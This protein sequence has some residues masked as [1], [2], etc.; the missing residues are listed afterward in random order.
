M[1]DHATTSGN[2][3]KPAHFFSFAN[4]GSTIAYYII[5]VVYILL[6][7]CVFNADNIVVSFYHFIGWILG[8]LFC[9]QN[10]NI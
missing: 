7:E 10:V 6:H 1:L 2:I 4:I 3:Q 8:I 9:L 5:V